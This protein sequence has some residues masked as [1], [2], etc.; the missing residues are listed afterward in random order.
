MID[1]SRKESYLRILVTGVTGRVGANVARHFSTAGHDVRG[2]V[3]P[4]IARPISGDA[5]AALPTTPAGLRSAA[6]QPNR[7][8]P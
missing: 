4:A 3:C 6:N 1:D 8:G 5:A 2:L 7:T